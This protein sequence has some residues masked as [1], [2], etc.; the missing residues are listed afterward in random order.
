ML[1]NGGV[2]AVTDFIRARGIFLVIVQESAFCDSSRRFLTNPHSNIIND[3]HIEIIIA[4]VVERCLRFRSL[5]FWMRRLGLIIVYSESSYLN[6][7]LN[8]N[9]QNEFGDATRRFSTN[10]MFGNMLCSRARGH[11]RK[12]HCL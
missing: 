10:T 9:E 8:S 2:G 12:M 7:V 1:F 4:F 6:T 3:E 11:F 5:D